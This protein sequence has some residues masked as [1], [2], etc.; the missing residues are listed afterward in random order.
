MSRLSDL[1]NEAVDAAQQSGALVVQTVA[2]SILAGLSAEETEQVALE[3]LCRRVK[4]AASAGRA[5]VLRAASA[6]QAELPFNLARAYA[7]DVGDRQVKL[8]RELTQI[9]VRR[10]IAIRKDSIAADVRSLTE[11]EA[12]YDAALPVWNDRPEWLFGQALDAAVK[13]MADGKGLSA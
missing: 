7:L 3:G 8:T 2:S 10:I 9:E 13:K 1:V 11:I 12:A 6:D 5:E 4:T